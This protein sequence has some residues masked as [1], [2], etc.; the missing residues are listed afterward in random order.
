[1]PSFLPIDSDLIQIGDL[2][3]NEMRDISESILSFDVS[4]TLDGA[5]ELTL[6]VLDVNFNFAKANYFQVRRDIFYQDLI[7]EIAAVEVQKSESIHPLYRLSCRNKNVQMMKRDKTP[8]AYR[9]TSASDYAKTVAKR[10]NM[11]YVVEETSKKQSIVKGRSGKSDESVW[12]VLQRS[13]NDAQFV[14]FETNN[15]LFFCSQQFLMGKWGDPK[16]KYGVSTFVPY[17]WPEPSEEA[18][19]GASDR[20]ILLDIPNVRRSDDDPMEADGS[21]VAER[22]NARLLRPG[23][24]LCLVGIPD[25]ENFYLITAVEFSEGK[26]DPVQITFRTPV[27]PEEE[28]TKSTGGSSGNN[29]SSNKPSGLPVNITNKIRDYINRNYPRSEFTNADTFATKVKTACEE[30]VIAASLIWSVKTIEGQNDAINRY[31]DSLTGGA[32]NIRYKAINHVRVL[33]RSSTQLGVAN[34]LT[35]GLP[36]GVTRAITTYANGPDFSAV[37][38]EAFIATARVDAARIYKATTVA[39]Q[40]KLFDEFRAKYGYND[41]QY[42]VLLYVRNQIIKQDTKLDLNYPK[43]NTVKVDRFR[44]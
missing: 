36:V 16:Y 28:Q 1:M 26:P 27:K 14:C 37:E 18:F 33:L 2:A 20:Y 24:T 19:P 6:E 9:A 5:S 13:A 32:N 17:G 34:I 22:T 40:N 15:I 3:T 12:D 30:A 43:T 29:G 35:A 11:E 7:F 44:L 8:E 41:A 25:F 39:Q 38:R 10:F 21:L 23:M 42:A 4:L 31:R